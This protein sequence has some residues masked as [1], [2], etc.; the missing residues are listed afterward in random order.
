MMFISS[1]FLPESSI[2]ERYRIMKGMDL[3]RRHGLIRQFMWDNGEIISRTE[4]ASSHIL[5]ET[6]TKEIGLSQRQKDTVSM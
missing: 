5:V 2:M 3:G 6:I 4:K 1:S